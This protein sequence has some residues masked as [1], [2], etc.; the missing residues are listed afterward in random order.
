MLRGRFAAKSA[1]II[2]ENSP[3]PAPW[4][5]L[6]IIVCSP[7]LAKSSRTEAVQ[8]RNAPEVKT[9]SLPISSPAAPLTNR[10]MMSVVLYPDISQSAWSVSNA[11][12]M[13][14]ALT[15]IGNVEI[16]MI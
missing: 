12:S 5:S 7:V 6:R 8:K 11:K 14:R 13:L 9:R 15:M 1:G 4:N 10:A 2:G 3:A 16:S